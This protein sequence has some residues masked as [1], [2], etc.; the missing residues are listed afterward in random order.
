[1]IHYKKIKI[2]AAVLTIGTV[3]TAAAKPVAAIEW[4]KAWGEQMF[5]AAPGAV[6]TGDSVTIVHDDGLPGVKYGLA[7]VGVKMRLG[8]KSYTRGIGVNSNNTMRVTLTQPA[9]RLMSD[10]GVDRSMDGHPA[11]V[12]FH[13]AV[14]GKDVFTSSLMKT[15]S[16]Q[17]IDVPLNGARVFDLIVDDGPD[18]RSFD[19]ANW[20]DA[21]VVLQDGSIYWLSD[22]ASR[23]KFKPT[24]PFSFTYGGKQS[25]E[26][27][28]AWNSR[29]TEDRIDATTRRRTLTLTDPTTGL[30]LRAVAN[31]Y[32]DSPGVDWTLYLTN[33]GNADTP[34]IEN[35]KAVDVTFDRGGVTSDAVLH[36]L[37][38]GMQWDRW[39]FDDFQPL[40]V[41]LAAGKKHEFGTPNAFPSFQTMPFFNVGWAGGEVITA[42]GWTGR[43]GASV[44]HAA[45]G[46]ISIKAGMQGMHL[47]L[48][49]GESI[50][51]PRVMQLYCVGNDDFRSYNLFRQTML[52]HIV[53]Q[54]DGKPA[55]LP[56]TY[57]ATFC[58]NFNQTTEEIQLSYINAIK[59]L[60]FDQ[61][62]LDAYWIK[63]GYPNGI[64]NWQI[65]VEKVPDPVR[66][67]N[68]LKPVAKALREA[69]VGFTLWMGI[70]TV[71]PGTY[72]NKEHPEWLLGD[73]A[74]GTTLN[75][76]NPEAR[77][78]MLKYI[79]S[80]IREY[81]VGCWFTDTGPYVEHWATLDTDP[82][83][84]GMT[85]IRYVEGL[86]KLWDDVRK[87]HPG[88][89]ISNCCG[90]GLRIDLEMVS[91]SVLTF[92]TD[93][94]QT[95]INGWHD[96]TRSTIQ[97]QIINLGLNRYIPVAGQAQL[98]S[99]PY[100][101][102]SGMNGCL[103][104]C[105]DVRPAD[106][107]KELL[108]Q[109]IA[110]I[111][112]VR[113]YWLGNFYPLSGVTPSY[114]EITGLPYVPLTEDRVK[115]GTTPDYHDWSVVQYHRP[116]EGDGI[117]IAFRRHES[118]FPAYIC[119]LKEIEPNARYSVRVYKTYTKYKQLTLSGSALQK[120]QL[121]V[122]ESP[123]SVLVEYRKL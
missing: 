116:D 77:E 25:S 48:H 106:Y 19:Q 99:D 10:I 111:K 9:V 122:K 38:G 54:I 61:Y 83:R 87:A 80:V 88:F 81:N 29:I 103:T 76:G 33:T 17:S 85:E 78:Y 40:D 73:K 49:P 7:S 98:G 68:G 117:V 109:A 55:E 75:L 3:M 69:G 108:K 43:W 14:D 64:G 52:K 60:G 79:D 57:A 66:F 11:S 100:N 42:I 90:G 41:P 47:K 74:G 35:L 91:R 71:M 34:V 119:N 21:R 56:I 93:G 94:A 18:D 5:S 112:R 84:K 30:E 24:F 37:H 58:N 23:P 51:S 26:F 95:T 92:R 72:I 89:L 50:R 65:P 70:E 114:L 2:L 46:S 105:D 36:L 115:R 22:L 121:D 44:E 8:D 59:G 97:N 16:L 113:K 28:H 120:L 20:A 102:R 12:V 31:I 39:P 82:D 45:D 104:F 53:P 15:G 118:P 67:P 4:N 13:V 86:Y 101:F 32:L 63:D 62:W 1:M 107:P 27:L 96:Q 6:T 123:G 110:E